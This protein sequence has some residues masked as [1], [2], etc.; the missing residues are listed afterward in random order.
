MQL[1]LLFIFCKQYF[2]PIKNLF[3]ISEFLVDLLGVFET[4][5]SKDFRLKSFIKSSLFL[6][7]F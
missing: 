1:S 3:N 5:P 7:F 6:L 2:F 4:N